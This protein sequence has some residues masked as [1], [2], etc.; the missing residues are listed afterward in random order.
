VSGRR[1]AAAPTRVLRGVFRAL[2]AAL[3]LMLVLAAVTWGWEQLRNPLV[4]PVRQVRVTGTFHY[5][6]PDRLKTALARAV[7]GSFFTVNVKAIQNAADAVPWVRRATVWRVWPATLV[8]HVV[9]QTPFARWGDDGVITPQGVVFFPGVPTALPGLARLDGP[10]DSG[11]VVLDHYHR[12][13]NLLATVGLQVA[14]V[15]LDA[16]RAWQI[17]LADGIVLRLGRK[18]TMRRLGR[19]VRAYPIALAKRAQQVSV[20]D[21]R[22]T[23]GFAVRWKAPG[24]RPA[25]TTQGS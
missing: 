15:T 23:N 3:V 21:L 24:G 17:D 4:F 22:Y 14:G 19:F 2:P 5:L 18:N 9:E 10:P 11:E 8:I 20:V 16:R 7:S 1:R 6:S 12:M 13:T 25:T